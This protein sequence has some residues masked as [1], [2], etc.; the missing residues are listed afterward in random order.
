M[1]L[2]RKLTWDPEKGQFANDDAANALLTRAER[3]PLRGAG[4]AAKKA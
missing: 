3:A 1:K 2:G 4:H